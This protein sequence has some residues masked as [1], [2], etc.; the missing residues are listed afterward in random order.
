MTPRNRPFL[1]LGVDV[2]FGSG[3]VSARELGSNRGDF[4]PQRYVPVAL[5]VRIFLDGNL[6]ARLHEGHNRPDSGDPSSPDD[7]DLPAQR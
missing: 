2:R 5:S 4:T 7:G 3:A 6:P 1:A